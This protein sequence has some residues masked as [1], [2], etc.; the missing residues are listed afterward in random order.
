MTRGEVAGVNHK[1][2][3]SVFLKL[4]PAMLRAG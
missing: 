4:F 2:Q 3:A 1:Q